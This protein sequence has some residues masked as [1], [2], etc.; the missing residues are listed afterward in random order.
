MAKG[1]AKLQKQEPSGTPPLFEGSSVY[2]SRLSMKMKSSVKMIAL[3]AYIE[4]EPSSTKRS[5]KG[6]RTTIQI[7]SSAG[8]SACS[9]RER[10]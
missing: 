4:V 3:H 7:V 2:S 1:P 9:T 8:S 6:W 10:T 5:E